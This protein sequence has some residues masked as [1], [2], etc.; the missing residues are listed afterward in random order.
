M[1][2]IGAD[3]ADKYGRNAALVSQ[4]MLPIEMAR[5]TCPICGAPGTTCTKDVNHG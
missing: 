5:R 2:I 4:A 3:L 1:E